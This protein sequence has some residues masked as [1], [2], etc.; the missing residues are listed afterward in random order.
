[1]NLSAPA[2]LLTGWEGTEAPLRSPSA[3]PKAL[4]RFRDRFS[5]PQPVPES[6]AKNAGL[7]VPGLSSPKCEKGRERGRAEPHGHS[8]AG[9]GSRSHAAPAGG[10]GAQV[11]R[12]VSM[13]RGGP[14]L[15]HRGACGERRGNPAQAARGSG[16]RYSGTQRTAAGRALGAAP[17]VPAASQPRARS[18]GCGFSSRGRGAES[19]GLAERTQRMLHKPCL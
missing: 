11:L 3:S 14:A 19:P 17:C 15:R 8:P 13:A 16:R 7:L 6:N 2:S 10:P 5:P 9:R 4:A 12:A 18:P 1:M